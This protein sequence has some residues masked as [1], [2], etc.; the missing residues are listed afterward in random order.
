MELEIVL[1]IAIATVILLGVTWLLCPLVLQQHRI[2]YVSD[3]KY[4]A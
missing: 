1:K 2:N 3:D 4:Y